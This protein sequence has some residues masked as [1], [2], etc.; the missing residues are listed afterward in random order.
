MLAQLCGIGAPK[1][2]RALARMPRE[3]ARLPK[4][5]KGMRVRF[6]NGS[7]EA[8]RKFREIGDNWQRPEMQPG[9]RKSKIA[10]I[11]AESLYMSTLIG[12]HMFIK[13][14]GDDLAVG[15]DK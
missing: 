12:I 13:I 5:L 11:T 7:N 8:G 9:R 6:S 3:F 1:T 15:F 2:V 4:F 14:G 10:P